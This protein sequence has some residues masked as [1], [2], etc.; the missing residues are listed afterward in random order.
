VSE[1]VLVLQ[2]ILLYRAAMV[3]PLSQY[4]SR[5]GVREV[6]AHGRPTLIPTSGRGR[7]SGVISV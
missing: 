1:G 4:I 2:R 6:D 3:V 5:V 7:G